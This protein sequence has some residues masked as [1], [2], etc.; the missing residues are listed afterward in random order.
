MK[1][2][3]GT[4]SGTA[5][6][7]VETANFSIIEKRGEDNQV[8][9]LYGKKIIGMEGDATV[10]YNDGGFGESPRREYGGNRGYGRNRDYRGG[11]RFEDKRPNPVEIGKEYEV[12]ITEISRKGGYCKSGRLC[13]I[14]QR[15]TRGQNAKI[16]ITQVGGRF[17]TCRY[18]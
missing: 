2:H 17:A 12:S 6:S 9:V 5:V 8:E 7:D 10:S 11:R 14:R 3:S 1:F 15:R 16:K 4:H 18:S 13:H